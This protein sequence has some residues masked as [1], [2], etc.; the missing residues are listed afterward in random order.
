[1][2]TKN[3]SKYSDIF[4]KRLPGTTILFAGLLM[5]SLVVGMTSVALLHY[6]GLTHA[7]TYI[8]I[9]GTLAGVIAILLPT[10]LT[11]IVIK[12]TR[13]MI[14]IKHTLFIAM[15]GTA[16]YSV[17]F[18]L[19]SILHIAVGTPAA[20]IAVLVGDASIFGWWFFINKVVLG[21]RKRAALFAL[22][23]PTLNIILFIAANRFIFRL[24]EP[25]GIL[26]LKLYIGIFI[27]MI[28]SYMLLYMFDRPLKRDL[29]VG[30]IDMFSRMLQ[31]WLF[32]INTS[33]PFS[34]KLGIKPSV[35]TNTIT[36]RGR[37]GIKGVF[38][39][40]EIHYGPAGS[41]GA[42]D[43]PYI[44]ERQVHSRYGASAFIMHSTVTADRNP[45]SGR[46]ID[47]VKAAL[48]DGVERGA[49][50][51]GGMSYSLGSHGHSKA[52]KISLGKLSIV[53][54]TR[55]PM[56]TED[57]AYDASNLFK[58]TL[59]NRYGDSVL[60]DAHNSRYESA[61]KSERDG[62]TF[63]SK[64][65]K[66]Y[67]KAIDSIKE[68]KRAGVQRIGI[69]SVE[70]YNS[71]GM[72]K[73]IGRGNLNAAAFS[74]GSFSYVLIQFNSNNILPSL[75]NE[76]V[77]YVKRKYKVDAEVC[78]TDTHSV[79]SIEW[80]VENVLGRY[81]KFKALV[82]FI[83]RAVSGAIKDIEPVRIYHK[84]IVLKKFPVWGPELGDI[85]VDLTTSVVAKARILSPIIIV[86]GFIIAAV[87]MSLV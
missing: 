11:V 35:D 10:V 37:D 85:M 12:A 30:G 41:L 13:H 72:P 17:F 53:T 39:I 54:L 62:V 57:V 51:K 83:D 64:A 59:N 8:L 23:Q 69:K 71:L 84:K 81:T 73:D 28:V 5:L 22:V 21:F 82:P 36:V 48:L 44:L 24:D 78:T 33:L 32:D 19:G 80:T 76:I 1:M 38:F 79:N 34:T 74:F 58:K 31:N 68:I 49:P 16:S 15:V 42:S 25:F 87:V 3:I 40:P 56:V 60:I 86:S 70:L 45:I 67:I 55:A 63:D 52:I 14:S 66:D 46:Q 20:V 27:F 61:P 6:K 4:S 47:R 50:L 29:G 77:A 43:Y 7:F 26:L 75:R 9:N 65:M 18:L 2:A